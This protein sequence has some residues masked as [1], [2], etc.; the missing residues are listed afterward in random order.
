[1]ST[2]NGAGHRAIPEPE[3]LSWHSKDRTTSVSFHPFFLAGGMAERRA[4][5]GRVLSILTTASRLVRLSALSKALPATTW[6][7]PSAVRTR[8][9]VQLAIPDKA[10]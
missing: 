2:V 3:G 7:A 9:G 10:S 6:L 1:M 4:T 5:E 8:G